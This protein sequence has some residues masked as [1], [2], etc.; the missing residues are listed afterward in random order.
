MLDVS[1][2]RMADAVNNS[3]EAEVCL[4]TAASG[5]NSEYLFELHKAVA[6][7]DNKAQDVYLD[8]LADKVSRILNEQALPN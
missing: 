4:Q 2:F 6:Q 1:V 8:T 7:L 3:Q 5:P